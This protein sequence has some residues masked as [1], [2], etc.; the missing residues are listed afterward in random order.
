MV[1]AVVGVGWQLYGVLCCTSWSFPAKVRLTAHVPISVLLVCVFLAGAEINRYLGRSR[2]W[3]FPI[4]G[5]LVFIGAPIVTMV[6]AYDRIEYTRTALEQVYRRLTVSRPFPAAIDERGHPELA[7]P[8]MLDYS[9]FVSD[10][11]SSCELTYAVSS[12][13]YSLSYPR[14]R[15]EW[16][17]ARRR[18]P[19]LPIL[20]E[21]R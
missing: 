16:I 12:D 3:R 19:A 1:L 10:D 13:G 9:Y 21:P 20:I 17:G 14:G 4:A 11:G 8:R 5:M 18:A 7:S 2:P 15:W 6:V